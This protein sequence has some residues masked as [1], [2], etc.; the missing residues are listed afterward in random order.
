MHFRMRSCVTKIL[1]EMDFSYL[2]ILFAAM[3]QHTFTDRFLL[4]YLKLRRP[5]RTGLGHFCPKGFFFFFFPQHG[6]DKL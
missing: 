1:S 2:Q 6:K 5:H 4:L 3:V